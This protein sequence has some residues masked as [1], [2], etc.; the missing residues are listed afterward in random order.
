MSIS[1]IMYRSDGKSRVTAI[2]IDAK[3]LVTPTYF[4]A[5][6]SFG[7]KHRV[8]SL[9]DLLVDYSYPRLLISA[10]DIHSMDTTKRKRLASQIKQY[11]KQSFVFVDSGRFESWWYKD[12]GWNFE[13]FSETLKKIEYDFYASLDVFPSFQTRSQGYV[14]AVLNSIES[15][16]A[17]SSSPGFIA[18]FHGSTPI[19][20]VSI[21]EKT[22][23]KVKNLS[24]II[25]LPERDCGVSIIDK[26]QTISKIRKLLDKYDDRIIMH[27]LGC[28]HPKSLALFSFCG[29]DTF[30]SLDWINS[31][32]DIKRF[33]LTDI[34]YLNFSDCECKF[35]KNESMIYI[36]RVLL[37]NLLFYQDFMKSIRESIRE[38]ELVSKMKNILGSDMVQRVLAKIR[39]E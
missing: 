28:G 18:V 11:M 26:V 8:D 17:I 10:Y 2:S 20:L 35:C 5:I 38:D 37:H 33:E 24:G 7:V 30:D 34:S 19:E 36:E 1:D 15:S 21:I 39:F 25:A 22:L 32:V 9:F 13:L 4:P 23:E 12:S 29:A 14:D 6:S 16:R 31:L 3:S 27:I